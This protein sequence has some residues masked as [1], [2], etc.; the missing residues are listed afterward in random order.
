MGRTG[1]SCSS[2]CEKLNS[3]PLEAAWSD[4]LKLYIPAQSGKQDGNETWE[5]K[6]AQCHVVSNTMN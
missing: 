3:S 6:M 5:G 4:H 1:N 2:K